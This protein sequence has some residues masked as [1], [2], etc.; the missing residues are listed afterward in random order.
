M[1]RIGDG[2]DISMVLGSRSNQ[3]RPADVDVFDCFSEFDPFLLD[4]RL[5]R[6]KVAN[7][8]INRLNSVRRCLLDMFR[9]IANREQATVDLR[10]E[11]FHPSIKH[12]G[13]TCVF[14]D[15]TSLHPRFPKMPRGSASR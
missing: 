6:I 11:G 10:V 13:K 2:R 12:F 1:T 3:R 7:D 5:K 4:R 9:V 14:R 8:E 15:L